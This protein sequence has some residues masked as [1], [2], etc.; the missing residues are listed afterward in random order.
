VPLAKRIIVVGAGVVGVSTAW[1]LAR[2]GLSV[3]LVDA[4]GGPGLGTS[5]ANGAQL[6]YSYTDAL[7]SP[8]LLRKLPWLVAGSDPAFRVSRRVDPDFLRWGLAFL[9][10]CTVERFARN[11][12]AGLRL[13]LASRLALD[14]LLARH[15]LRFGH[16]TPG[17]LLLH[18]DPATFRSAAVLA[19]QKVAHGAEQAAVGPAEALAI[20]PA[21]GGIVH[22]LVGAIWAPGEEVGDPHLFCRELT[23]VLVRDHGVV[24]RFGQPAERIEQGREAALTLE[25]G[26]RLAADQLVLCPGPQSATLLQKAGFRIPI[27]PVRGHSFTAPTGPEAPSVS[28][29]DVTRKLVFCQLSG[30]MRIAGQADVGV[31]RLGVDPARLASLVGA[32]RESLPLAADYE[33]ITSSWAGLRPVTPN[34]LP[35]VERRGLVTV[36]VGHGALGWT[37]ALATAEQA[38]ALVTGA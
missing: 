12:L 18:E 32:A 33:A 8:R 26:E 36:N 20:E 21:L 17:K 1:A 24:T 30:R 5:F 25:G 35:V 16:E 4:G 7:A 2:R 22:R 11:T 38:A 3:T 37:Y 29:T 19:E 14:D 31:S 23:D 9:S 10:N 28:L 27:M 13:G 34:S 6:S 15:P